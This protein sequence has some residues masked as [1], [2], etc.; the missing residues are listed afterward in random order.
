VRSE[1]LYFAA[2]RNR[3]SGNNHSPFLFSIQ[4]LF[5]RARQIPIDDAAGVNS[6]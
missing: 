3:R 1:G 2:K 6:L 5:R 4:Q